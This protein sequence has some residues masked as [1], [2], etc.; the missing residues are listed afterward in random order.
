MNMESSDLFQTLSSST[1]SPVPPSPFVGIIALILIYVVI[2]YLVI[3]FN[4]DYRTSGLSFEKIRELPWFSCERKLTTICAV[5][6]DGVHKGER[7]GNFPRC[8]HVFHAQ[9]IDLWLVRR[10]SCPTCRSPFKM[11]P[12]LD[13]VLVSKFEIG[14]STANHYS[15]HYWVCP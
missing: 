6:L 14:R 10:L 7:C 2:L 15:L 9:C 13:V 4:E 3:D 8:K 5:C 11:E 12:D 1:S